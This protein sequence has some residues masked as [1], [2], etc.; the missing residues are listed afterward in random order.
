MASILEKVTA[1]ASPLATSLGLLLWGIEFAPGSRSVLRVFVEDAHAGAESTSSVDLAGG[2][3]STTAIMDSED[4]AD[5]ED[6][7]NPND[8]SDFSAPDQLIDAETAA[9]GVTIKQCADLSR[10]LSLALDVED[11]LPQAY[12]LE[13]SSPGLDRTFFTATQLAGAIG[14]TIEVV[15]AVPP[16]AYPGRRKFRGVL[17][18]AD[19]ESDFA[20][21]LED[22]SLPGEPPALH[23]FVF[24]DVKKVKQVYV[25]PEK[26]RPGKGSGKKK[27]SRQTGDETA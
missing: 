3:D 21:R 12:V 11:I 9:Q 8:T 24:T 6:P 23:R 20:M 22:V 14:S 27:K 17:E 7:G 26:E 5:S 13:V 10:L 25:V 18:E 1:L 4:A 2:N 15:Y 19:P 16:D